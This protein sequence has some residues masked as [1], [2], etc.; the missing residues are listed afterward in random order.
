M[1][2]VWGI[3][4]SHA[5]SLLTRYFNKL[6]SLFLTW[7]VVKKPLPIIGFFQKKPFL[8]NSILQLFRKNLMEK[9]KKQVIIVMRIQSLTRKMKIQQKKRQ[10]MKKMKK[11]V[12]LLASRLMLIPCQIQGV[13]RRTPGVKI[14]KYKL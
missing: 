2:I 13:Y 3:C 10:M 9:K 7:G 11:L 6:V 1:K 14:E 4:S 8:I 12:N 5:C